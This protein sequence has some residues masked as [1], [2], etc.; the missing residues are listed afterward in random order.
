MKLNSKSVALLLII[1]T[2]LVVI[3]LAILVLNFTLSNYKLS[4]YSI[5]GTKAF[6]F[7]EAGLQR[8]VYKIKN[9][10]DPVVN[11]YEWVFEGKKV[12]IT[13]S[14]PDPAN[15]TVYKVVSSNTYGSTNANKKIEASI[16]KGNPVQLLEWL[17]LN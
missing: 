8:A 17:L 15:P 12:Y 2:I 3:I 4:A 9:E 7:A 5:D 14:L 16:Q 11:N 10:A 6:Y 13:I 1:G